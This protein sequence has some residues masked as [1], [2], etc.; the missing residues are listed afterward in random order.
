MSPDMSY[1]QTARF[2]AR[3]I[4]RFLPG[5]PLVEAQHAPGA[6][7]LI[8]AGRLANAK[9]D[10]SVIAL[11]SSNVIYGSALRLPGANISADQLVWLGG[12]APDA[13][14]CIRTR[15]SVGKDRAWAGSLG[16]GSRADVHARAMR[17]IAGYPMEIATGYVSRF[18]LVRALENGEVDAACGWP[19]SD[20]NRRRDEWL[21]TGKMYTISVF[22]R[23]MKGPTA[24]EWLPEGAV[25]QAFDALAAEAEI[26]W[27]LAAPPGTSADV[28]G[29]FSKAL[30]ALSYDRAAIEDARRAGIDLDPI[31]AATIGARVRQLHDLAPEVRAKLARLY[32]RP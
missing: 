2:L 26:A 6:A 17:D 31:D 11:L 10:G 3:H 5:A 24:P 7:G 29:A 32:G 27:P 8:A 19:L 18:E 28:A 4:G 20:L 1:D 16:F 25:A 30:E 22:S 15:A 13:W 23:S 21:V 9:P 14:A 12:V